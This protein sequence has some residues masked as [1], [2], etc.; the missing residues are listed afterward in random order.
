[1]AGG[2]LNKKVGSVLGSCAGTDASDGS[3]VC[4]G[5]GSGVGNQI[6]LKQWLG[7]EDFTVSV[8]LLLEEVNGTAASIVFLSADGAENHVGLDGGPHALHGHG[9]SMFL[10]GP[11]PGWS[12]GKPTPAPKAGQWHNLTLSRVKQVL[13][14]TVDGHDAFTAPMAF[15]VQG[16]ALRPWRSTMHARSFAACAPQLPAPGAPPPPPITVTVFTPGE[17]G[18]SSLPQSA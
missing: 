18:V 2:A 1:M 10:S 15:A 11:H 4:G 3:Y 13:Q 8:E 16:V 6:M 5:M 12:G 9:D 7:E 17:S 14:I